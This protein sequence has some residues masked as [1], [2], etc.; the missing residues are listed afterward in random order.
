MA[1]KI[2]PGLKISLMHL[3]EAVGP[4]ESSAIPQRNYRDMTSEQFLAQIETDLY[5]YIMEHDVK[6]EHLEEYLDDI[7]A[8]LNS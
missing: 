3:T 4:A 7:L 2:W 5:D 8:I 6:S 1:L